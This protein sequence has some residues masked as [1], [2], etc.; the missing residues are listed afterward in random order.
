M[1]TVSGK[2]SDAELRVSAIFL[3]FLAMI[4]MC[5]DV[6]SLIVWLRDPVVVLCNGAVLFDTE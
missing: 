1:A 2:D 3:P 4:F 6:C 5:S